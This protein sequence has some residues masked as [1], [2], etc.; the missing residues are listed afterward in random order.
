MTAHTNTQKT[1]SHLVEP[2]FDA[3]VEPLPLEHMS[4][5][6]PRAV[7]NFSSVVYGDHLYNKVSN[8]FQFMNKAKR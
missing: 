3:V 5:L 6:S 1:H 8:N 4:L 2:N 7:A